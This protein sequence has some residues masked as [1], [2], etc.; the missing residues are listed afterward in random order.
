[1]SHVH[2]RR[3]CAGAALFLLCCAPGAL[4]HL[5]RRPSITAKLAPVLLRGAAMVVGH[6]D[7]RVCADVLCVCARTHTFVVSD[8]GTP[9][10]RCD[11]AGGG[12]TPGG[13]LSAGSGGAWARRIGQCPRHVED[14]AGFGFR[15]QGLGRAVD[16]TSGPRRLSVLCA[17]SASVHAVH[18]H[19]HKH[20]N[21]HTH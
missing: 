5:V 10:L 19:R 1:M 18:I 3:A 9:L 17:R 13:L 21:T 20:K 11:L 16:P 7:E 4:G 8:S 2:A 14:P 12:H 15:V 6:V